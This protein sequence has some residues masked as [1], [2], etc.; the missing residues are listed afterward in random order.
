[1][2]VCTC[3]HVVA[4]LLRKR[5]VR[6]VRA[7]DSMLCCSVLPSSLF[8]LSM[9][10]HIKAQCIP[11][12]GRTHALEAKHSQGRQRR[13]NTCNIAPVGKQVC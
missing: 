2:H 13:A 8:S 6:C 7:G 4:V 5:Q 12:Q 9:H 11:A 1:M 10:I 3:A